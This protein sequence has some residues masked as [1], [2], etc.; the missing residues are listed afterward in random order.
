MVHH[1][2]S[3]LSDSRVLESYLETIYHRSFSIARGLPRPLDVMES[4]L[5]VRWRDVLATLPRG[6]PDAD[7]GY[8]RRQLEYFSLILEQVLRAKDVSLQVHG[9]FPK[10]LRTFE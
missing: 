6:T 4:E 1:E 9:S 2:S 5:V 10:S 8:S 7:Y 3:Y